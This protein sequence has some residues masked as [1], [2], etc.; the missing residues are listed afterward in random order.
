MENNAT[1]RGRGL[2]VAAAL[3]VGCG[4]GSGNSSAGIDRGG[5]R[6]PAYA[7]G[8]ITGFG[9]VIVRGT[10]YSTNAATVVIDGQPSLE[11]ALGVGQVVG[12]S[13]ELDG[14]TRTASRIELDHDVIGRIQSIATGSLVVMNQTVRTDLITS[15]DRAIATR[16]LEGL[17]TGDLV[18]ISGLHAADG[19]LLAG[20]IELASAGV[21][22]RVRGFV[23]NVDAATRR[24]RVNALTVDYSAATSIEGFATGEP[25]EGEFVLVTGTEG[26]SGTLRAGA[27]RREERAPFAGIAAPFEATLEGLV[28]RFAS[29][30]DFDVDGQPVSTSGNTTFQGGAAATVALGRRLTVTGTV[31]AGGTLAAASIAFAPTSTMRFQAPLTGIDVGAGTIT[32]LGTTVRVVADTYVEDLTGGKRIFSLADLVPGDWVAVVGYVDPSNST[33]L[34]ATRVARDNDDDDDIEI[35]GPV[36]ALA[37]PE[38]TI[39]TVRI[40]TN[41]NTEFDD[42]DRAAFFAGPLG[43]TVEVEGTFQG[44]VVVAEEVEIED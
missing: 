3:L 31:G 7:S 13:G 36:T 42:T 12:V 39:L 43:R 27:L 9:S 25:R 28:T 6:T 34:I 15:F 29:S 17:R 23:R 1:L 40:L 22:L 21:P 19:T 18:A 10:T 11:T 24:F 20:R 30:V 26:S 38:F 32:L 41:A 8:T 5:V 35:V 16:S 33:R 14:G 2:L 37:D 4:G 44:N